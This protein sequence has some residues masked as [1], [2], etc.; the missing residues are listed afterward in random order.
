[1]QLQITGIHCVEVYPGGFSKI[2]R[3]LSMFKLYQTGD[4]QVN[5]NLR[6]QVHAQ[7]TSFNPL[8]DNNTD[9]I[10]DLL[11]YAPKVL[12]MYEEYVVNNGILVEQEIGS[13]DLIEHNSCF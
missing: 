13:L 9:D 4:V 7:I 5:Q 2:S 8:K 12:E 11:C 10:L 1:V 6:A 3:I